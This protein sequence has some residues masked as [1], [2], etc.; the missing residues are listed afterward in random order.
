MGYTRRY[1]GFGTIRKQL[2]FFSSHYLQPHYGEFHFSTLNFRV[3]GLLFLI[4]NKN[5]FISIIKTN[6]QALKSRVLSK[7]NLHPI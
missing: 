2:Y 6:F 5:S 4:S 3:L 7:S 1:R